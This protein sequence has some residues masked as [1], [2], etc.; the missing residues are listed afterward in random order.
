VLSQAE[1]NCGGP[2]PLDPM[3]GGSD[4]PQTMRGARV[5]NI[6]AVRNAALTIERRRGFATA[7]VRKCWRNAR[8]AA[9]WHD[10]ERGSAIR[11]AQL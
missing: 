2:R 7:V 6:C 8:H 9:H 4:P 5:G 1:G 3:D 10:R 11:A